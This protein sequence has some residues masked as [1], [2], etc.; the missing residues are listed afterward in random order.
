MEA[1]SFQ[2]SELIQME[3]QIFRV[4]EFLS[5]GSSCSARNSRLPWLRFLFT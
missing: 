4:H 1:C 2:E 3:G 5:N